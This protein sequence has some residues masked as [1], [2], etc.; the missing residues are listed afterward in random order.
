MPAKLFAV[1]AYLLGL[2]GAGVFLV[3]VVGTG[4]GL[5]PRDDSAATYDA[6]GVNFALLVIFALQHS[7]M[8]RRSFLR[9]PDYLERS[10]YV[11]ASGLALGALTFLWRPLPGEPIWAGPIWIVGISVLGA[12]G[13]A[14][15][16]RFD[17]ATF[18]G[19][20]PAWTQNVSEPG[21]LIIDGPYRYVRHP[22]MLGFLI[23]IWAQ[24]IM[25]PELL[26]LNLGMTCYVGLGIY[27]EER[28]LARD[29]GDAYIKYRSSVPAI[30]PWKWR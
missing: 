11:G 1:G 12:V 24:P 9:M 5:W 8:Q 14:W 20:C 16:S 15:C 21:P 6:F 10:A 17:H 2:A 19:L 3:Y 22:L 13:V 4:T 25:P 26:M 29:Y 23:T 30:L 7:G 27:L 28:D 18:F